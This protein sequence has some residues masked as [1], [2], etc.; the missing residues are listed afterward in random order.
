MK[1]QQRIKENEENLQKAKERSK[2][3]EKALFGGASSG[4]G[5]SLNAVLMERSAACRSPSFD[6]SVDGD[7]E[8]SQSQSKRIVFQ[9]VLFMLLH[10]R[11]TGLIIQ[12]CDNNVNRPFYFQLGSM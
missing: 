3:L 4:K 10:A 5:K 2:S 8:Q 9:E 11:Q 12:Y 7:S 6:S 1:E